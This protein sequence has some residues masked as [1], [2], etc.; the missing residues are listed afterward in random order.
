MWNSKKY[1]AMAIAGAGLA[2]TTATPASACF[3]W[4][5]SGIYS[6]GWAYA[7]TGF[8]DSP[9][10]GYRSCGGTYLIQGWGDCG[11]Y[12]PCGWAPLPPL[13]VTVPVTDAAAPGERTIRANRRR[14]DRGR[15]QSIER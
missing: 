4:G 6:Y 1:A 10:Y 11:G 14:A 5:H 13:V 2:V 12:G 9:A 3:T 15:A 8:S 7:S